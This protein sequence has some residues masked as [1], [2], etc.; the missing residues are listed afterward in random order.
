[1]VG[2]PGAGKSQFAAEFSKMFHAPWLDSGLLEALSED[3]E[4]VQQTSGALLQEMMKT[5]QTILF[6][7]ATER[8]SWRA[9]LG[10]MARANGYNILFVWVQADASTAKHRWL[11]QRRGE[12][13]QFEQKIKQFSPP[14]DSEPYIVISGH[15]TFNTQAKTL[16]RQLAETR[17]RVA[18]ER[19][20]TRLR[21][22]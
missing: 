16:L 12:V 10:R 11:K 22:V 8:R 3:T 5:R 9:E 13:E 18:P 21:V 15:H 4:R 20:A 1:M 7:G 19:T 17:P 6:E 2:V 14:H